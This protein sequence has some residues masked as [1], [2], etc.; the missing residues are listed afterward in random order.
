[1]K[2]YIN[3]IIQRF[4]KIDILSESELETLN[5]MTEEEF[6]KEKAKGTIYLVRGFV[7]LAIDIDKKAHGIL[8]VFGDEDILIPLIETKI[9]KDDFIEVIGRLDGQIELERSTEKGT[10]EIV[11]LIEPITILKVDPESEALV[12]HILIKKIKLIE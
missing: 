4:M 8:M 1:M 7:T 5:S 2:E 12:Q 9:V 11:I 3:Q 10:R 6:D